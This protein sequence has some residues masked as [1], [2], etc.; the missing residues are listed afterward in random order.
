MHNTNTKQTKNI[1]TNYPQNSNITQQLTRPN[2]ISES[3][4][5]KSEKKMGKIS[6]LDWYLGF[7]RQ[8]SVRT[9]T[10]GR[11]WRAW[12][13]LEPNSS[14]CGSLNFFSR[15]T[16]RLWGHLYWDKESLV[17]DLWGGWG[18]YEKWPTERGDGVKVG[19]G[20][21]RSDREAASV[22]PEEANLIRWR[23]LN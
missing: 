1:S 23:R 18:D 2:H 12:P 14:I 19:K 5:T 8:R 3:L 4:T 13:W 10:F 22:R 17:E 6:D 20:V 7:L 21:M 11:R 9:A 15:F 16:I